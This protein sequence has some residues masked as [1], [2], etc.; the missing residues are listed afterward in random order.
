MG[1][2]IEHYL[3]VYGLGHLRRGEERKGRCVVVDACLL[4]RA[5]CAVHIVANFLK[6]DESERLSGFQVALCSQ[7]WRPERHANM[8][9][10][11]FPQGECIHVFNKNE[12]V[13]ANS[14]RP[15]AADVKQRPHVLLMGDSLGDIDMAAGVSCG[16]AR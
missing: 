7:R 16:R 15:V 12:A 11:P 6:F 3:D 8:P 14:S 5:L 13:V 10:P 1:D 2:I 9:R 4:S